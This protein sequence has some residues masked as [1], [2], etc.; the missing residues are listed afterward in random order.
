M[1]KKLRLFL[2]LASVCLV[3]CNPPAKQSP[4]QSAAQLP[5]AQE[6][7][8]T[9]QFETFNCAFGCDPMLAD[10]LEQRKGEVLDFNSPQNGFDLL[11]QCNGKLTL[12][13]TAKNNTEV[14]KQLNETVSPD[15]KFTPENTGLTDLELTTAEAICQEEGNAETFT[16]FWVV[17]LTEDTMKVYFEGAS[18]LNFKAVKKD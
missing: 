2:A 4:D 7:P 9:W 14:I 13:E 17:S 12:Q 15:T 6:T 16:T 5:F 11:T 3:A 1:R 8:T 10:V 18:F